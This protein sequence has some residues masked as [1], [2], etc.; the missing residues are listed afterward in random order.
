[1]KVLLD[2]NIVLDVFLN[3]LPW[4]TNSQ[5]IWQACDDGK[6][7]G[8]L[9]ATTLTNIYYIVRRHMNIAVAR[10]CVNICLEA[11]EIC[12]INEAVLALAHSLNGNDFEDDVQIAGATFAGLDAIVTRDRANGFAH[13]KIDVLSPD[14]LLVRIV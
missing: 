3:R 9:A 2:I 7:T 10:D 8:Y 1:M 11:F 14:D 6:I 13:A 12:E 4:L 5:A